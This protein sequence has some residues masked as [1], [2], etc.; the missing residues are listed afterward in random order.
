[1]Q[2]S[3]HLLDFDL[4]KTKPRSKNQLAIGTLLGMFTLPFYCDPHRG[5]QRRD[6]IVKCVRFM[7]V[8]Y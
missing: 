5:I 7:F 6:T 8:S 2:K 3:A 4:V 1:M